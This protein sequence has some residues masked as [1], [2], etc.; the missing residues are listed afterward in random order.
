MQRG[1]KKLESEKRIFPVIK[2]ALLYLPLRGEIEAT[3]ALD[4]NGQ[5][6]VHP[7]KA[8]DLSEVSDH[9]FLT[10]EEYATKYAELFRTPRPERS[11]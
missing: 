10:Y 11:N 3:F 2:G 5:Q 4:E 1:F 7:A 6:W 9:E 8:V